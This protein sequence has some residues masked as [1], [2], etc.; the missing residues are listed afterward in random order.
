MGSVLEAQSSKIFFNLRALI[1]IPRTEG[2][3]SVA[4]GIFE[5]L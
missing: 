5:F 3:R 1:N 4:A 2:Y